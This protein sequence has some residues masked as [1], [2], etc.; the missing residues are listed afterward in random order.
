MRI[1]KE[2]KVYKGVLILIAVSGMAHTGMSSF[3]TNEKW[4]CARSSVVDLKMATWGETNGIPLSEEDTLNARFAPP[5][6][7]GQAPLSYSVS[8]PPTTTTTNGKFTYYL[9]V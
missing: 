9:Y 8:Q 2:T 7:P 6:P 1:Y 3:R 4:H 5:D